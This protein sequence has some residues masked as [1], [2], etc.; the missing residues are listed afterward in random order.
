MPRTHV[1]F[2]AS[3]AF[4]GSSRPS[5]GSRK[6][7][8]T[9][10]RS[11]ENPS[12]SWSGRSASNTVGSGGFRSKLPAKNVRWKR[13]DERRR[14]TLQTLEWDVHPADRL[15]RCLVIAR[16]VRHEATRGRGDER[17]RL[18][19][20]CR[21]RQVCARERSRAHSR[22]VSRSFRIVQAEGK[23][24]LYACAHRPGQSGQ[25]RRVPKVVKERVAH[26]Q[27]VRR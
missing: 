5:A 12:R 18:H 1:A 22:M 3:L 23:R 7:I 9:T 16:E 27:A 4:A 10:L 2:I 15:G 26:L 14:R 24:R 25:R 20:H 8:T 17:R 19:L 11:G 13:C 6:V 21:L